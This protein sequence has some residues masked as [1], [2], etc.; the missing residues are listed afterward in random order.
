M[1]TDFKSRNGEKVQ[2]TRFWGGEQRG[3]CVQV[4][5]HWNEHVQLT[6]EQAKQLAQ[7]LLDF[8]NKKEVEFFG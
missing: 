2:L 4:N 3:T 7:D 5:T 1:T 8:A 6:R